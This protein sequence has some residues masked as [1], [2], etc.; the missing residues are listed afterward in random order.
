LKGGDDEPQIS[1]RLAAAIIPGF[2][3]PLTAM[4]SAEDRAM[5]LRESK[6]EKDARIDKRDMVGDARVS[7]H[8]EHPQH[9]TCTCHFDVR[10][11]VKDSSYHIY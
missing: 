3:L 5:R 10:G 9:A 11:R 6:I 1:N 4:A 2:L 7:D 8:R